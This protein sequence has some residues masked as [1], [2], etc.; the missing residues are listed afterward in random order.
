M[1]INGYK[2]GKGEEGEERGGGGERRERGERERERAAV[3]AVGAAMKAK[4]KIGFEN[5]KEEE[6]QYGYFRQRNAMTS[7]LF[8][9]C[10]AFS[11]HWSVAL[12]EGN[13]Q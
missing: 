7:C 12:R 2:L 5:K 6:K 4:T 9:R 10:S 1:I 11:G 8:Y 3:T 13:K